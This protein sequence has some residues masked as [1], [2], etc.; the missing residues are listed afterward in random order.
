MRRE[1][2][3]FVAFLNELDSQQPGPADPDVILQELEELLAGRVGPAPA[4]QKALDEIY[5]DA[6]W[7]NE[8]RIPPG[9]KDSGKDRGGTGR[10]V[11]GG[12]VYQRQFGDALVWQQ[13]LAMAGAN[14]WK[15]LIF[16]TSDMKE[17]WWEKVQCNGD[18][19]IGARVELRDEAKR[20]AA[21][22][23]LIMYRE[24]S[25]LRAASQYLKTDV[26][27]AAI[28]EVNAVA[29]EMQ[30]LRQGRK[31]E[32]GSIVTLFEKWLLGVKK[33]ALTFPGNVPP[34][35]DT[36]S[37]SP[38]GTVIGYDI[39]LFDRTP[40][41][42]K[43]MVDIRQRAQRSAELAQVPEVYLVFIVSTQ[44]RGEAITQ[45]WSAASNSGSPRVGLLTGTVGESRGKVSFNRITQI[46]P[47]A[48][49]GVRLVQNAIVQGL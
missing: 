12:L 6:T 14:G 41:S 29:N 3:G 47:P 43:V 24:A 21:V 25:F 30:L 5:K 38:D 31:G 48:S 33:H 15:Q 46:L 45:A 2:D 9:F 11:H 19:T 34:G 42:E 32:Y 35:I 17:D 37:R 44:A 28:D 16:V 8:H 20:V 36:F 49:G 13:T 27:P 7:R 26:S 22:E 1:R 10:Y 39:R 40:L 23:S 18:V 4:D